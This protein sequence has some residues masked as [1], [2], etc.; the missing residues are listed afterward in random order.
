M[1]LL[2]LFFCK[3]EDVSSLNDSTCGLVIGLTSRVR[4]KQSAFLLGVSNADSAQNSHYKGTAE[5]QTIFQR[6]RQCLRE[7]LPCSDE[8]CQ[9]WIHNVQNFRNLENLFWSH[10]I[11]DDWQLGK[12]K[13]EQIACCVMY[14]YARELL[15]VTYSR[16]KWVMYLFVDNIYS[17][18]L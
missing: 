17:W 15:L 16:W 10:I 11:K 9:S 1:L 3:G 14:K 2:A 6:A 18:S 8:F 4:Q 13:S 7:F 12:K 5:V